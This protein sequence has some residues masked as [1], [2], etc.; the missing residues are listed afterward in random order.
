MFLVE[1]PFVSDF[2]KQT[3]KDH[4]IPVVDTEIS[5]TLGRY[6]GTRLLSEAEAINTVLEP[7]QQLIYTTSENALGWIIKNLSFSVLVEK[8]EL[9]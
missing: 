7:G 8:I 5:R 1:K 2:F 9:F 4:G 3:V 6:P